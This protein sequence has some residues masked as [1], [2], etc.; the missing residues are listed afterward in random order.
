MK[1]I[2][3]LREG[4]LGVL[5]ANVGARLVALGS[6]ALATLFVARTGGAVAVGIY[7]LVRVLPGLVGVVAALGLPG[8]VTVV[9]AGPQRHDRRLPLSLVAL[10]LAGGTAGTLAWTLAGPFLHAHLFGELSLGLVLLA[11]TTVL[12]QLIVATAKSSSQGTE[13][14]RGA[15]RVIVNEELMF[16]PAYGAMWLAGM[17][18]NTAVVVGLLAADVITFILGWARLA[19]RGFFRGATAPSY[20]LAREVSVYGLRQ[21]VGGVM[22]LL[23]LRL[24]FILLSLMAGPA[25][26]GVYAIASKVA[27]LLKI[28]GMA[29]TYVLYPRYARLGPQ[30][31]A[32]R[33]RSLMTKATLITAVGAVPLALSAGI[34]IPAAYGAE[35]QDA[36][37]PAQIIVAGLV[38]DGLGGVLTAYLYGIG[39]P[40]LNS[41]AMAAGLA[42]TVALDLLL[43]PSHGAVGA[44]VASA[45]AYLTSTFALVWFYWWLGR[46]RP[47]AAWKANTNTLTEADAL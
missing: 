24:D 30:A 12:T 4:V 15:N 23:N 6:L 16:L 7:A 13:D 45:V 41:W 35:F 32:A 18:G 20:R 47:A 34:V 25:V 3:A 37:L 33:V 40:G 27:E 22:T 26:L 39:R 38:L 21:Q 10:M 44:A 31:A 17:H 5:M 14:M 8:A 36:V 28:P 43:I 1:R 11:G 2:G 46:S 42:V 19:R 29:L 9:V